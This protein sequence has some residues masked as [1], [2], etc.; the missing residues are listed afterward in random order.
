MTTN[1]I[2]ALNVREMV[3]VV[4]N[5]SNSIDQFQDQKQKWGYFF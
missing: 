4:P 5:W 1:Q 2:G 3:A